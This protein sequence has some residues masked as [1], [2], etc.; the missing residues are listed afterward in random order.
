MRAWLACLFL[1]APTVGL[2]SSCALEGFEKF[3]P[4]P[5][6]EELCG[7]A[8]V[9]GPPAPTPP[10]DAAPEEEFVVALRVLRLKTDKD[11]ADLGLDLDR[12]CSC[13]G[14]ERSCIPPEGQPEKLSCDK[15]M[16]RDNQM[17]ALFSLV[18]LALQVQDLSERYSLFAEL[19]S[20]GII[21][22]VSG[23]NGQPNDSKVRVAWYGSEGTE[24]QPAWDGSDAWPIATSTLEDPANVNTPKYYDND[25]YVTDGMLVLSAP[26]GGIAV[27]GGNTR[28]HINLS[29]GTIQAKILK[30]NLGRWI[31]R[32]G[33]IAGRIPQVELF[34]M[35]QSFRDDTGKPFCTDNI[36]WGATQDAFCRGLDVQTGPPEPNKAC[37]A[38]SFAAGFDADPAVIGVP[39]APNPDSPGCPTETDPIASFTMLGCPP[40]PNP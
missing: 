37:N 8:S 9:P 35:V 40:P 17:P 4:P 10:N 34:R 2:A 30:D 3:T 5:E 1:L 23:Y 26:V 13:Q 20:W 18:E 25:A 6:S 14:E 16:G 22:H 19:G 15:A 32:D 29:S 33:L 36:F 31:L 7:H 24:A 12:F 39:K 11:G 28:L 38:V 21:F 27:A